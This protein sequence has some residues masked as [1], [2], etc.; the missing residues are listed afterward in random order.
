MLTKES[1]RELLGKTGNELFDMSLALT[2]VIN[3]MKEELISNALEL[4][5]SCIEMR[6]ILTIPPDLT[7]FIES[8]GLNIKP[9]KG[10]FQYLDPT[11]DMF[12]DASNISE[13]MADLLLVKECKTS[14]LKN[15][16]P[17]INTPGD[18]G[19]SSCNLVIRASIIL[20]LATDMKSHIDKVSRTPMDIRKRILSTSTL[21]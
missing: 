6:D 13:N 3:K 16:I 18:K 15:I 19:A 21:V 12:S 14:N 2:T 20:R 8:I 7:E 1:K 17:E 4:G 10:P 11:T 9:L 5:D